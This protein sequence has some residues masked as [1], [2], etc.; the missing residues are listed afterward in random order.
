MR[1]QSFICSSDSQEVKVC[2]PPL[3]GTCSSTPLVIA[4]AKNPARLQ[5]RWCQR[6]SD[7]SSRDIARCLDHDDLLMGAQS[8]GTH[9]SGQERRTHRDVGHLR[10]KKSFD[11][12]ARANSSLIGQGN[13]HKNTAETSHHAGLSK[14]RLLDLARHTQ[15]R[16]T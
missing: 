13:R 11:D 6:M 12:L 2:P 7:W 10:I 4:F 8:K 15:V 5:V 1:H 14:E 16:K 9:R 3:L